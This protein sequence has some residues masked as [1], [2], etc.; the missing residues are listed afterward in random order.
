MDTHISIYE[1]TRR[2]GVLTDEPRAAW[3][4]ARSI[5]NNLAHDAGPAM[6]NRSHREW[7]RTPGRNSYQRGMFRAVNT[8][9]AAT[10]GLDDGPDGLNDKAWD[11]AIRE[12]SARRAARLPARRRQPIPVIPT[13]TGGSKP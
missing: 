2:I 6:L 13:S 9:R 4:T 10:K 1:G 11:R 7:F 5:I 8:F 12:D 3:L